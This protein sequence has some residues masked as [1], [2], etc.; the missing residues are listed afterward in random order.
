MTA[1]LTDIQKLP[2]VALHDHLDGGLRP[3]TL[4]ELAAEAGHE[5]PATAPGPLADWFFD[6]ANSG[7]LDRYLTTFDHT[8]A[9]M[10]TAAGLRRIARE[11]VEDQA[12]DGVVYAEARWA[13]QQHTR[14]GLT[15][16]QAVEA[17][18]DGLE[19]GMTACAQRGRPVFARQLLTA[20]RQLPPTTE[21]AELAISHRGSVC[22]FDIAGPEAGFPPGAFASSFEK[23]RASG[24]PYT[25]HAGEAWGM[26]SVREAVDCGA[27]RLGHG[28]RLIED[29]AGDGT[30]GPV[31]SVVHD[32][33]IALEMCPT[34]NLQ[35]GVVAQLG[36]HPF[37]RFAELGF[38]ATVS[39]DNRLM[40]RTTLSRELSLLADAFGYG[41]HEIAWF[42][43]DAAAAAFCSPTE[44]LGVLERLNG[45]LHAN[46][47]D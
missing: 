10:Q 25:I 37:R 41:L 30:L 24:V 1:T 28:V 21:V 2:K 6:A 33:R 26:A 23:L 9:V 19:E 38:R 11:F 15:M 13:P 16:A 12:A 22:G 29:V 44:R 36:E 14:A 40:S 34:S 42:Q 27:S 39:C 18:R 32:R 7:S 17:V 45:W 35:T 47:P 20:M 43:R 3:A 31:A 5:L 46:D 8:L 4:I